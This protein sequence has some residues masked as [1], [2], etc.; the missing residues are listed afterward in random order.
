MKTQRNLFISAVVISIMFSGTFMAASQTVT[1]DIVGIVNIQKEP[2]LLKFIGCNFE[3]TT[4]SSFKD[5]TEVTQF[6][7]NTVKDDADQVFSKANSSSKKDRHFLYDSVPAQWRLKSE[8]GTPSPNG[9]SM[10]T[11]QAV[12]L[13]SKNDDFN[14]TNPSFTFSGEVVTAPEQSF[15]IEKGRQLICFPFSCDINVADLVT[16][17]GTSSTNGNHADRIYMLEYVEGQKIPYVY[18]GLFKNKDGTS[19]WKKLVRENKIYEFTEDEVDRVI[20]IGEGFFYQAVKDFT[21]VIENPYLN[22]L[23]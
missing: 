7:A 19:K 17:G 2:G 20:S 18:F 1:S 12:W 21:W 14:S 3:S 15:V 6:S 8:P 11:G 5:F 4:N 9:I 10:Q 23:K 16:T 13:K 22:Y